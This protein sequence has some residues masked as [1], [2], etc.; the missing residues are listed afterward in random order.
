MF[1]PKLRTRCFGNL[2]IWGHLPL[3]QAS[4]TIGHEILQAHIKHNRSQE[5]INKSKVSRK[6]SGESSLTARCHC[7]D[8]R[9]GCT[10]LND[11]LMFIA[12]AFIVPALI[13]SQDDSK[14]QSEEAIRGVP[15]IPNKKGFYPCGFF[16]L[17][18]YVIVCFGMIPM[19]TNAF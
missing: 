9:N 6:S 8:L 12:H 11:Q 16:I 14:T 7:N 18:D 17:C 3:Y 10:Y 2:L 13:G 19:I 15:W 1:W 4:R 5:L